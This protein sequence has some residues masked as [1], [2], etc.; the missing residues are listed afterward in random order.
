MS[1]KLG[2]STG[3]RGGGFEILGHSCDREASGRSRESRT[4]RLDREK[5]IKQAAEDV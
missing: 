2:S 4:K 3:T 1:G 5:Q